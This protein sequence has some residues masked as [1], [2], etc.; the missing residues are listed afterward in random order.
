MKPLLRT[1]VVV[2]LLALIALEPAAHAHKLGFSDPCVTCST[3][4]GVENVSLEAPI[5]LALA[6]A[7]VVPPSA[8]PSPGVV[9]TVLARPPP[10]R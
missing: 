9:R 5:E 8:P 7:S 4:T 3:T 1:L 6:H 10:A 2:S